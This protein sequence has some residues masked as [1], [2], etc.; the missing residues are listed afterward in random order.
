MG[1][2]EELGALSEELVRA[3]RALEHVWSCPDEPFACRDPMHALATEMVAAYRA[4]E[5]Q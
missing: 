2:G 4:E 5:Q 3:L 1:V